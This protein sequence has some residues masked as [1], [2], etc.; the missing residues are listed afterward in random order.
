MKKIIISSVLI[1][2]VMFMSSCGSSSIEGTWKLDPTS[3]DLVLGEGFPEE[4]KQNVEEAKKEATSAQS[5]EEA[6][7]VTLELLADGKAL[8]KHAEHADE[9]QEFNWKQTGKVL[10]LNGEVEGEKFNVN[11]DIISSSANEVTIGFT[12]ES[13]LEQV[14]AERP[15][16]IEQIPAMFD[17]KKLVE[18]AK[19]SIKMKKA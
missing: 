16:L 14:K 19:V 11:L 9:T 5:K 2:L 7:K 15:E 1:A 8:L 10:N 17:L 18:G 3:L 4:M 13:L 6:D 12:G